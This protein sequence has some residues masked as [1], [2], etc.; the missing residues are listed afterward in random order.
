VGGRRT[1]RGSGAATVSSV[2]SLRAGRSDTSR[3]GSLRYEAAL[4]ATPPHDGFGTRRAT[5]SSEY[6]LSSRRRGG[7]L[8][9]RRPSPERGR[10]PPDERGRSPPDERGRSPP[11]ERGR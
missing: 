4:R 8:P 6:L 5:A 9:S 1:G 7:P 11:D 10:S 3:R 2:H